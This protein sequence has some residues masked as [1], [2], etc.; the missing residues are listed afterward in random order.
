MLPRYPDIESGGVERQ[1]AYGQSEMVGQEVCCGG[2]YVA[3]DG[4]SLSTSG[5][6]ENLAN[7]A[8]TFRV[9]PSACS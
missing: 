9:R 8:M 1:S 6:V 5:S 4:V 2:R 3:Q 7:V